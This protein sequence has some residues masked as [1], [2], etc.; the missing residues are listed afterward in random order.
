MFI[1]LWRYRVPI[2]HRGQFEAAY[3]PDGPWIDLFARADGYLGTELYQPVGGAADATNWITGD[4]W[5]DRRD[6]EHFLATWQ[7]DYDA[8]DR[9]LE[10]IALDETELFAGDVDG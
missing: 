8:L 7:T 5:A 2:E 4:Q 6:W 9:Q 10:G 1:R 3:G